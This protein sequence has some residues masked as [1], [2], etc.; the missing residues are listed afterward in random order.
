M[1]VL[2]IKAEEHQRR[3]SVC[4]GLRYPVLFSRLSFQSQSTQEREF[5]VI[6]ELPMVN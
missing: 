4:V 3:V 2:V 1:F 6:L 5:T